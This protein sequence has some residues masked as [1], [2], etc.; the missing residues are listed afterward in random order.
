M[1]ARASPQAP[2]SKR[3]PTGEVGVQVTVCA[4]RS[5][6]TKPSANTRPAQSKALRASQNVGRVA[7]RVRRSPGSAGHTSARL[8]KPSRR[9]RL[10]RHKTHEATIARWGG[11]T[12]TAECTD[13]A[14]IGTGCS[15]GLI[16]LAAGVNGWTSRAERGVHSPM[17][18]KKP[19]FLIPA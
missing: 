12:G 18:F 11:P 2:T 10:S 19:R 14:S 1:L 7:V 5:G 8:L 13:R 17:A 9:A 15:S 6:P 4:R 3:S 16:C